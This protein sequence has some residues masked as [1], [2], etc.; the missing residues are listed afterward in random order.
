MSVENLLYA[1]EQKISNKIDNSLLAV[2]HINHK[3][4][5]VE[6][7]SGAV[8]VDQTAEVPVHAVPGGAGAAFL[9]D[10]SLGMGYNMLNKK[11]N[12]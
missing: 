5:V 8:M 2:R 12:G 11:A 1:C 9:L 7:V 4:I 3:Y 10:G 6:N